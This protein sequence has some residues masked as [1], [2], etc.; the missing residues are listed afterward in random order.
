MIRTFVVLFALTATAEELPLL[1]R[2][3]PG[4]TVRSSMD[5]PAQLWTTIGNTTWFMAFAVPN[6]MDLFK[7]D[8]T[9]E[10]TQRMTFGAGRPDRS[11][12]GPFLG[13]VGGKVIYG[14]RDSLRG[15]LYALDMNGGA[16]VL[17]AHVAP[18]F[19]TNAVLRG[20]TLFFASRLP[21]SNEAELWRT[22]GT[23]AGTTTVELV[24]GEAGAFSRSRESR[25][26]SIGSSMLFFGVT[27]DGNGLHRTDGTTGGTKLLLPMSP[28]ELGNDPHSAVV[29]GTRL[30][31]NMGTKL[32]ASDGTEA[33]TSTIADVAAS[34]FPL[35]ELGGRLY[36]LDIQNR[37]WSTDGTRD[38]T[39]ATDIGVA[40]ASRSATGLGDELLFYGRELP[41]ATLYATKGTAA[42]TRPVLQVRRSSYVDDGF[43]LGSRYYFLDYDSVHGSELWSTDGVTEALVA[44]VDP[45]GGSGLESAYAALRPDGTAIFIGTTADTGSEPWITDGTAA[46][47]RLVANVAPEEQVHSSSPHALRASGKRVFFTAS[48]TAGSA[49]GLS[50]GTSDGTSAMAVQDAPSA[51][52]QTASNGRY[53]FSTALDA[54][55]GLYA[56]DGTPGGTTPLGFEA[57]VPYAVPGGVVFLVRGNDGSALWF[58]NG[59]PGGTRKLRDLGFTS[60]PV[61]F[62]AG[63]VVWITDPS[64]IWLT[65]GTD[66]GTFPLAM[67]PAGRIL[68]V[69][70]SGGTF[71]LF[72]A[73]TAD[74]P[75]AKLW[76]SDGTPAGT[77]VVKALG[78]VQLSPVFAGAAGPL[79]YFTFN[80]QIHRSDGTEAGTFA[81]PVPST[82][83][84]CT[85][86]A[87][88]GEVLIIGTRANST[89][90]RLFRSDG[91]LGGTVPLGIF[92]NATTCGPIVARGNLVYFSGWDTAHG[93]EPWVTDGTTAGTRMLV[94]LYPGRAGSEPEELTLAEDRI[95][96]SANTPNI[97]REL[98]AIGARA[99][100]PKRRA[101]GPR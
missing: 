1:V 19:L 24:Q 47:T 41:L 52:S 73:S 76:R 74:S 13:A 85:A 94:D 55:R 87:A 46:G 32:Y 45:G 54:P 35:G 4:V 14:G 51:D 40:A 22:D 67:R 78:S 81:L 11:T 70:R 17:L 6:A 97:G 72:E 58:S 38:G 99:A 27:A 95:F 8:G 91:T 100:V 21:A 16:P 101:A 12:S 9:P 71:Y 44:D 53:F 23:P 80:N 62:V 83:S 48:L 30:L 7:T 56:S 84:Y 50:D 20:D 98:W 25:L 2:D 90:L 89:S 92:P 10:G 86:A 57:T 96:F 65:D 15:G 29:L 66:E 28:T 36:F 31:F 77:R 93:W 60:F 33:G 61:T 49:I 88:L 69:T 42:T 59:T 75:G 39:R 5:R 79:V 68:D 82:T 3:L 63:D 43:V 64:G 18:E 34:F 26:F 37:I